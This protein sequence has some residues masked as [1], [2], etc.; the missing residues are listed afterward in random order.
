MKRTREAVCDCA[1]ALSTSFLPL[2]TGLWHH[3]ALVS[4]ISSLYSSCSPSPSGSPVLTPPVMNKQEEGAVG[5]DGRERRHEVTLQAA[6]ITGAWGVSCNW[7]S[8]R[9]PLRAHSTCWTE[10]SLGLPGEERSCF[11]LP[12]SF[13]YLCISCEK[14]RSH[15]SLCQLQKTSLRFKCIPWHRSRKPKP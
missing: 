13:V 14:S 7:N 11:P 12:V 9:N 3:A 6:W 1:L 8:A 2:L 5:R 4:F 10:S 15:N